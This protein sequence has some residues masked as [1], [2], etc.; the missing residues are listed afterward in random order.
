MSIIWKFFKTI[1]EQSVYFQ[2][3]E[4]RTLFFLALAFIGICLIMQ[5]IQKAKIRYS[6]AKGERIVS[7]AL[8]KIARKHR[9]VVLNDVMLPLYDKTTQIDHLVIGPFGVM[10]IETKN[11]GGFIYGGMNDKHWQQK[12]GRQTHSFYNPLM[13]NLTHV[14]TVKYLLQKEGLH[15]VP[16]YNLVVFSNRQV[17]VELKEKN[18]PVLPA[19]RLK[20]YF[21][22][23]KFKEAKISTKTVVSALEKHQITDKKAK[24]R[25][26]RHLKKAYH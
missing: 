23:K 6:G 8:R 3:K 2:D 26:I 14:K 9:F 11:H 10:C 21:S 19:K 1:T 17:R 15:K 12:I 22:D 7:K 5:G 16:V 20:K 24:K 13:Q 25:H 4:S 18:I